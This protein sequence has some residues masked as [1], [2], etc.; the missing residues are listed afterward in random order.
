MKIYEII[1]PQEQVDEGL[2]NVLSKIA[3]KAAPSAVT[4]TRSGIGKAWDNITGGIK[5]T[6]TGAL[7]AMQVGSLYLIAKPILDYNSKINVAK[8]RL[9]NGNITEE[10]YNEIHSA[11]LGTAIAQMSAALVGSV[12]LRSVPAFLGLVRFIPIIGPTIAI[13]VGLL[14]EEGILYFLNKVSSDEGRTMIAK[15]FGATIIKGTGMMGSE[16]YE[17]FEKIFKEAVAV[18]KGEDPNIEQPKD[19]KPTTDTQPKSDSNATTPAGTANPTPAVA[20]PTTSAAV[21]PPTA[22]P[23]Q[24]TNVYTPRNM[25]RDANGNLKLKY[26]TD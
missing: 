16:A 5:A 20:P 6:A 9:E 4:A 11:L 13:A 3:N 8:E 24:D 22:N 23:A 17:Y 10:K 21:T 7:D 2:F 26:D 25:R 19:E 18:S 12:F 1:K 15:F 14:S